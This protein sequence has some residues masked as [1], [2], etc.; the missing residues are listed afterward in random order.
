MVVDDF[1][2]T[3][4]SITP[5]KANPPLS[6]D[7]HAML[8]GVISLQRLEPVSRRD[9]KIGKDASLVQ[10][11]QSTQGYRLYV[12]RQPAASPTAP[13]QLRFGIGKVLDQL[14]QI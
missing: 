8:T 3:R 12:L 5:R 9:E 1:D 13:D 11:T 4:S 6:V 7:A 14:V 2:I 10:H